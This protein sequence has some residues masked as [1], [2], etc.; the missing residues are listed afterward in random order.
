MVFLSFM[1]LDESFGVGELLT[2]TERDLLNL[3]KEAAS[4]K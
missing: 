2:N 4:D 1:V 3:E